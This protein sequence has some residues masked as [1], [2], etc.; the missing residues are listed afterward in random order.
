VKPRTNERLNE[1]TDQLRER[2]KKK[3]KGHITHELTSLRALLAQQQP[4]GVTPA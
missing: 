4:A 3:K 2:K 1:L